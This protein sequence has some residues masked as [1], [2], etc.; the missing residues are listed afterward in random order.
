MTNPRLNAPH[1]NRLS[2]LADEDMILSMLSHPGP[3]RTPCLERPDGMPANR[4]LPGFRTLAG[5]SS[6]CCNTPLTA[7]VLA[8]LALGFTGWVGPIANWV[9]LGG[10]LTGAAWGFVSS[11]R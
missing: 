5:V 7:S 2:P 3:V 11:R 10:L 9:H 6:T 1:R 4:Q 8:L